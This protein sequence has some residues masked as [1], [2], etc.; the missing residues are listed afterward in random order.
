MAAPL[1]SFG[2]DEENRTPVR[3]YCYTDFSERSL[4]LFLRNR[5]S[6]NK[7]PHPDLDKG[8]PRQAPRIASQVSH[9]WP[10]FCPS[11]SQSERGGFKQPVRN[12]R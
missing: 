8:F 6:T 11:G 10:L 2:G 5:L 1:I 3:K 7:G 9:I 4:W 12:L